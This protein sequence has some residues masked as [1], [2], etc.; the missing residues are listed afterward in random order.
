MDYSLLL[1][2]CA[3]TGAEY[4]AMIEDDV[5]SLRGWFA[6]MEQ[7]LV[8]AERK[9]HLRGSVTCEFIRYSLGHLAN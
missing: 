5:I 9:T 4:V 8:E 1:D 3:S 7:A 6:K 2:R